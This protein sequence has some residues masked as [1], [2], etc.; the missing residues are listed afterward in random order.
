MKKHAI[1][2]NMREKS[3]NNMYGYAINMPCFL[4]TIKSGIAIA[5]PSHPRNTK[6]RGLTWL[7]LIELVLKFVHIYTH[8]FFNHIGGVLCPIPKG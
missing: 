1:T 8:Q 3:I 5:T 2:H 4:A 7:N 6:D